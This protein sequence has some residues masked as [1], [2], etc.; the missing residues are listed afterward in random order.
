MADVQLLL[1]ELLV[2]L[3]EVMLI[4]LAVLQE[5]LVKVMQVALELQTAV[6][7]AVVLVRLETLMQSKALAVMV[8]LLTPLGVLQLVWVKTSQEPT[9]LQAVVVAGVTTQ[10]EELEATEEA[11]LVQVLPP[12]LEWPTLAVAVALQARQSLLAMAVQA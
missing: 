5:H 7:V 10:S 8:C 4:H 3:V 12:H 2:V 9:G 1:Q 11:E 6:A